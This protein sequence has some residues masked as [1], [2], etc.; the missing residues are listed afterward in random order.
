MPSTLTASIR[1]QII[2]FN[3]DLP[4]AVSISEFCKQLAIRRPSAQ[5]SE[6]AHAM[7]VALARDEASPY[8]LALV[9][10]GHLLGA[11][12]SKPAGQGRTDAAWLWTDLWLTVEAKS[13]QTTELLSM[14][15]VR[16]AN[17]HLDSLASDKGDDSAPVA[18]VSVIVAPS[19]LVDPDAV[20]IAN[21]NLYLASTELILTLAH[22]THRAWTRLRASLTGL[23]HI[24][25][26]ETATKILWEQ[27]IL[28]T[29]IKDRLTHEPI[30]GI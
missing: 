2:E 21:P 22:E 3:P 17:T 10:L 16:K 6:R 29:Q 23:D 7:Q 4:D 9:E 20:P 30:R 11:E 8:E 28:P 26:R 25:A 13:E 5:F 14:A 18:S 19:R 1:R 27:R 24:N 12:S 15:Y